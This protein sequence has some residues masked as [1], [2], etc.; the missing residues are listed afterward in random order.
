MIDDYTKSANGMMMMMMMMIKK[1][2]E[3]DNDNDE[4]VNHRVNY[5]GE[6]RICCR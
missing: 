5:R 6:S 4:N 1:N 2:L 3:D